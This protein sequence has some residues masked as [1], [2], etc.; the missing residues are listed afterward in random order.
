M[1]FDFVKKLEFKSEFF[2]LYKLGYLLSLDK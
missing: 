1:S 2:D